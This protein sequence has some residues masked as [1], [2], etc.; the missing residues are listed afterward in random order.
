MQRNSTTCSRSGVAKGRAPPPKSSPA[1]NH[2]QSPTDHKTACGSGAGG[3]GGGEGESGFDR[4]MFHE[5]RCSRR[6]DGSATLLLNSISEPFFLRALRRSHDAMIFFELIVGA[7]GRGEDGIILVV[8][9]N[10]ESTTGNILWAE[11]H[12][13]YHAS[14]EWHFLLH[15]LV[16]QILG[17]TFNAQVLSMV[18]A[19][20][21]A[22]LHGTWL[23]QVDVCCVS[24]GLKGSNR[25]V[26]PTGETR[27]WRFNYR[28]I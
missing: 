28:H 8:K 24:V 27:K 14:F 11:S 1:R 10:P 9:L 20:F 13:D 19:G 4:A 22:A 23:A 26:P 2:H 15:A 16:V 25:R 3:K 12:A 21:K 17:S 6:R 5:S 7:L 18:I